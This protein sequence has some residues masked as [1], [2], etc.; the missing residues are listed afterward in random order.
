[1]NMHCID[2]LS[3][4]WPPSQ[5][6]GEA[7]R[8]GSTVPACLLSN[9]SWGKACVASLAPGIV[10]LAWRGAARLFPRRPVAGLAKEL[11]LPL[12]L[13][14]V[15]LLSLGAPLEVFASANSE[16]TAASVEHQAGRFQAA[17]PHWVQAQH[18]ARAAGD[19][20]AEARALLGEATTYLALGRAPMA[21]QRLASAHEL[22]QTLGNVA[23]LGPILAALGNAQFLAGEPAKAREALERA[24]ALGHTRGDQDLVAH[25]ANDLAR[26][27]AEAGDHKRAAVLYRQ[28]MAA[29]QTG[30][31]RA[32]EATA[33]VNLARLPLEPGEKLEALSRA[34]RLVRALPPSHLRAQALIS[35]ARLY[36][37]SLDAP[38]QPELSRAKAAAAL[39]DA[40]ATARQTGDHGTLSYALGYRGALDE[41]SGNLT[42]A[43]A[44]SREAAREA[45]LANAPE[46]LY[47]WE[48]Q[49]GRILRRLGDEGAALAAYRV[50]AGTL[51]QIRQDLAAG[52]RSS[53]RKQAG[54]IYLELADLL[55]R[56]AEHATNPA[57]AQTDLREARQTVEALKGAELEDYFQD[58]CVAA[59][60]SK[61]KGID[62]LAAGTAA[63][64][65][66]VLPDRLAILVSFADGLRVYSTP[67]G[68]RKLETEARALRRTLENRTTREYLRHARQIYDWVVRPVEADLARAG[69]K[70]LV[71][72]PDGVLRT[73]PLSALHDGKA[74]LVERYAV[75]TSPGLTLTDPRPLAGVAPLVL[76]AGLTDSVQGFPALPAVK[77]E[78]AGIA[79][80]HAG[81]VLENQT[82]Q[83]ERFRRE[84]AL[85]PYT[86]VHI[87]SHGEFGPSAQETFLLTHDGRITLDQLEAQLGGTAYRDQPVELLTLSACQ[88]AAGDDRAAMGLAGIAVKAG[89]RSAFATLWSVND[90]ASS[91][92][93]GDFYRNLGQSGMNKAEA[94]RQSQKA[95]MADRRYR[96]PYYW[97]PFLLIGNWL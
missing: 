54:P 56:R 49:A 5:P 73:I 50:A 66:I 12:V 85:R 95:L 79:S 41:T 38:D 78:I 33:A 45:L 24:L 83:T 62:S 39:D 40:A 22:A 10:Q 11:T 1:M 97:S 72:I 28:A 92:L 51:E 23:L 25:G 36:S 21:T 74:F 67:V 20:D 42:S 60:K 75:T 91:R 76:M 3:A 57:A 16:F 15:A 44:L 2:V 4:E 53:F 65:P 30:G 90:A 69:I 89:A 8:E 43:L 31:N 9:A 68:A 61:T 48:W 84:L 63:L 26:L 13:L 81:T 55:L 82:F 14:V 37:G 96:H 19:A 6:S 93:V 77:E 94:L 46:S 29:A 70:T 47:R 87:A 59:L 52:G 88:T 58:D 32:L 18:E 7:R 17:L 71:L 64:Y 35:V 86:I 80:H 34:E 27:D